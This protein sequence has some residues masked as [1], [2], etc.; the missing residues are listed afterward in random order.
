[1]SD[2]RSDHPSTAAPGQPR[3]R[4]ALPWLI[5]YAVALL[6][7]AFWPQHVDKGMGWFLKALTHHIPLLTYDRIEFGSN[8]VLFVPLGI[9][10]AILMPRRRYLVMPIGFVVSLAIESAQGV[11][12]AGRTASLADLIANTAGACI[13]LFAVEVIDWVARRRQAS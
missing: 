3:L 7:I 2:S 13:G 4:W 8:I 1:M 11:L 5:V 12:L 9:L 10:L 6:L